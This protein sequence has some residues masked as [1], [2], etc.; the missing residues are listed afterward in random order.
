MTLLWLSCIGM[1]MD[2]YQ[3]LCAICI[4]FLINMLETIGILIL[5][6]E[7]NRLALW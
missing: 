7:T 1:Y 3:N 6:V 4:A 2:E 5:Y